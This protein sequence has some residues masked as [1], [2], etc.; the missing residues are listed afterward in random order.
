MVSACIWTPGELVS[1]RSSESLAG[2]LRLD[3]EGADEL[4]I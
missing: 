3:P 4:Q 1:G 2:G